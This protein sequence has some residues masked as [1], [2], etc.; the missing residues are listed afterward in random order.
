MHTTVV[1][2]IKTFFYAQFN[3]LIDY[4]ESFLEAPLEAK[5]LEMNLVVGRAPR[6]WL[7]Q[8]WTHVHHV[9][10]FFSIQYLKGM[11]AR[12]SRNYNGK[13]SLLKLLE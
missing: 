4:Q 5:K 7:N 11:L 8:Y 10:V 6:I 13:G 2:G 1:L 3:N 9:F 12:M